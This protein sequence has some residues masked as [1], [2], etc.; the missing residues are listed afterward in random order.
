MYNMTNKESHSR[1]CVFL[2]LLYSTLAYQSNVM[3]DGMN[4]L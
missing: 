2:A 4:D 3:M 1:Q